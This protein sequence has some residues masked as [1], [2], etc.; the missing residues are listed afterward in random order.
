MLR[1]HDLHRTPRLKEN[2]VFCCNGSGGI[3]NPF[4]TGWDQP[5]F[6]K[7][8]PSRQPSAYAREGRLM[9]VLAGYGHEDVMLRKSEV[10]SKH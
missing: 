9:G 4:K 3:G 2:A 8:V 7:V 6:E 10:N 1:L 5:P